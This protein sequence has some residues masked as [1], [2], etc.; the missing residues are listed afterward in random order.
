MNRKHLVWI[1]LI[2]LALFFYSILGGRKPPPAP[3]ASMGAYVSYSEFNR[4]LEKGEIRLLA[5][6][7][8]SSTVQALMK[9]GKTRIHTRVPDASFLETAKEQNVTVDVA[10]STA[11]VVQTGGGSGLLGQF[12]VSFLLLAVFIGF[13]YWMQRRQVQEMRN[14]GRAEKGGFKG[15]SMVDPSDNPHRLKDVA[16]CDEIKQEVTEIVDF[17]RNPELYARVGARPAKGVLMAGPPGTGKTL[18]AKAIA[19]EA[20]V[21]FYSVGGSDF[22]EMFV[23]MGAARVRALFDQAK[24]TSPSIIFIDEID[25]VG[26][27]RSTH[28]MGG[29]E[30]REQT[31]NALLMEMDGFSG[32]TGV[33]VIAATNRTDILD[34]ALRR[35]GRFDREV[36][37]SLPDRKGREEILRVHA[38]SVPL[39]LDVSIEELAQGTPGFSGAELA[40]LVN[41][42]AVLAARHKDSL[43]TKR[44]FHEARDKMIMGVQRGPLKNEKERVTVAYHEAGHAIVAHFTEGS[45]PVHKISIVPRGQALGVTVQLPTE[46]SYN[47]SEEKL[48]G[49]IAVLM[50][51]RAA[52]DV[53]LSQRT[54]GASNDF[55]RATVLARRMIASWGMDPEFGP[56]SIDGE[57]GDDW[58][59]ANVWSE[60]LKIDAD[61][62]VQTLLK[63]KYQGACQLLRDNLDA[64]HAV[65]K[66]L[67]EKESLDGEEFEAIIVATIQSRTQPQAQSSLPTSEVLEHQAPTS[68]SVEAL[69]LSSEASSLK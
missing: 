58:S 44:H 46:D 40:N 13:L 47:H 36:T 19:G 4:K 17:L 56:V 39:A 68:S 27:K 48:L 63:N 5:M 29:N 2:A 21:P 54:V 9:D 61:H 28:S 7:E 24:K 65:S 31:L 12:L 67:L 22:T 34:D 37:M 26:R 64:L 42:A 50:G 45:N 8:G 53:V 23:G 25:A 18:L 49:D 6:E 55:M 33:I 69:N 59:H 16:G 60:R 15:V 11:P 57:R 41:E 3:S 35:P 14:M 1:S 66:A 43:V 51:G 38:A 20:G 52:E 62:R 32:D 10:A 30:E